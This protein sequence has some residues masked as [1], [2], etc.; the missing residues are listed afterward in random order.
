MRVDA[1]LIRNPIVKALV[2]AALCDVPE[3]ERASLVEPASV[4]IQEV[5]RQHWIG[6][7]HPVEALRLARDKVNLLRQG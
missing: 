6:A 2:D 3:A 7:I 4:A 1:Q 5:A